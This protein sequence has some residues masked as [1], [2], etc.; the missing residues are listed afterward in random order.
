MNNPNF[1]DRDFH[2][3]IFFRDICIYPFLEE[4]T[5]DFFFFNK[6]NCLGGEPNYFDI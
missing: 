1:Y 4:I 6:E 5:C 2:F 3:V